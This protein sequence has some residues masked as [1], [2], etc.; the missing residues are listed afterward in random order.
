MIQQEMYNSTGVD[1]TWTVA[2]PANAFTW[3][4]KAER[5]YQV[6]FKCH[7]SYASTLPTYSPDGFG[8]DNASRTYRVIPNGL[9]KLG[10]TTNGQVPDSRDLAKEFNSYQ[11]S[12]HP[13]AALGRNRQMP[14]GSFTTGWSQDSI[15]SCGDCHQNNNP[16]SGADGP[17]GSSLLHILDG[18]SNYITT[19]D[20]GEQNPIHN[21]GELCFKCHQYNTYAA[22]INPSSTTHFRDGT[23]NLHVFHSFAA[24]Y[25]CHDTHGS[26][27]DHLIN[28][29]T[30]EVGTFNSQLAWQFNAVTNTGSCD[31]A[32]HGA[33]HGSALQYNP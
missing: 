6:C 12:F 19:S 17:H 4:P 28:F 31:I 11:V 5:E 20:P 23:N 21:P 33:D 29:D 18:S 27:Q 15:V 9:P 3:L 7:S 24:C 22:E 8:W 16:A 2:G 25:T 30:T 14:A 10:N 13:V 1:P 26:E 32:C